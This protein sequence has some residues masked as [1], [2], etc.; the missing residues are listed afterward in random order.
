[1]KGRRL[2]RVWAS[3]RCCIPADE[4]NS[5]ALQKLGPCIYSDAAGGM[6]A[7]GVNGLQERKLTLRQVGLELNLSTVHPGCHGPILWNENGRIN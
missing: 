4:F 7:W 2:P 3:M 1:M 5:L 6:N